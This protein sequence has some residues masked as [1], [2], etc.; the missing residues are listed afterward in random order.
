MT[1]PKNKKPAKAKTPNLPAIPDYSAYAGVGLQDA[2]MGSLPAL[3]IV[4]GNEVDYKAKRGAY[5]DA[6]LGEIFHT[7]TLDLLPEWRVIPCYVS[8]CWQRWATKDPTNAA[9]IASY[10][11]RPKEARWVDRIGLCLGE[12][13]IVEDRAFFLLAHSPVLDA[14]VPAVAHFH[15]TAIKESSSWLKMLQAPV[16]LSQDQPP[17]QLPAM[18]RIF[19][20]GSNPQEVKGKSW[21]IWRVSEPKAWVDPKGT[22]FAAALKLADG[23]ASFMQGIITDPDDETTVTVGADGMP[24]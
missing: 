23:A 8:R 14:W 9:P 13:F 18:S 6:K 15:R 2:P 21:H 17:V 24:F 10:S 19:H 3:S 5:K 1:T 7:G 22:T 11:T 12:N 20:L 16:R 4:S